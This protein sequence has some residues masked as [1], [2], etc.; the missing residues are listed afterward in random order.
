MKNIIDKLLY[1]NKITGFIIFNISFLLLV[2]VFT[3]NKENTPLAYITYPLSTYALVFF[4][5][6]FFKFCNTKIKLIKSNSKLY[7]KYSNNSK[8]IAKILLYLSFTINL[9][10]GLF[11]L[12][13]GIYY[14]SEWF[15][16]F[17]IYYL[18]L[19]IMKFS[20]ISNTKNGEFG[21]NI[22]EEYKKLK[23]IGIILLLLDLVLSGIIMLII[24]QNQTFIYPEYLIYLVALYD[25]CL[26]INAFI[27]VFKYRKSNSPILLA[28]KCINLT[29]AMISIISLEVAMIYEFG[30]ND[31]NFKLIMISC[32][33]FGVSIINSFMAIYMIFKAY[34]NKKY[35]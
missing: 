24:H 6:W 33:G 21:K 22:K 1:P 20:I 8:T 25:F 11:K 2:Y 7:K 35:N 19:C 31:N 15:I 30:S 12:I 18:L 14:K 32:T 28:S 34:T 9:I 26:I 4:C 10:Y 16:T 13:M 5:I 17:A 27:K 23:F 3:F 29:V